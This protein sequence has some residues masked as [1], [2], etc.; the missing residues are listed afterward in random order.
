M[1][2]L[3]AMPLGLRLVTYLWP[4]S[5]TLRTR[6]ARVYEPEAGLETGGSII[7]KT[8]QKNDRAKRHPQIFNLQSSIFNS[9]LTPCFY[10]KYHWSAR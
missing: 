7:K 2:S 1:L 3:T 4:T 6:R 8:Y 10:L 9:G 5:P